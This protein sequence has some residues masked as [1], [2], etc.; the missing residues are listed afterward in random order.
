MIETVTDQIYAIADRQTVVNC[1]KTACRT[2]LRVAY[3][4]GTFQTVG[5][6]RLRLF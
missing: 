2:G 5:H 1:L 3:T 4:I 6:F